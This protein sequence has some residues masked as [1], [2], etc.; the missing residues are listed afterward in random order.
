MKP[1]FPN[2]CWKFLIET[3][4]PVAQFFGTI[5]LLSQRLF[6]SFRYL[7]YWLNAIDEHSLHAP[8][9]FKFYTE[10]IKPDE[11]LPVFQ[12]IEPYR[13]EKLKDH[14]VV[15]VGDLG[16]PSLVENG[17]RR[18]V[19]SIARHSLSS[20]KSSRLLWRLAH[21]IQPAHIIELGTSLGINT[22]YLSSYH[23]ACK[24]VTFE[25]CNTSIEQAASLFAQWET[26]NIE[27]ISGNIDDTLPKYLEQ[28]TP[29]DM[30]YLDA[31]HRYEPTMKY[32][33]LLMNH[34]SPTSVL[35]LDDIHWSAEME[36]AWRKI[37]QHKKVTLSIDIFDAGLVFFKP[38]LTKQ[39]Y[40]LSF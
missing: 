32:F 15:H 36:H 40:T 30:V 31:N 28:Y 8:F 6:L 29:V 39:H 25:G 1:S 22:L 27:L 20:A 13:K 38:L 34:L 4:D 24:V 33:N 9:I 11:H 12:K 23:P 17:S 7:H 16:A 14:R 35:V 18:K 3:I 19:S 37:K 5:T 21:Y 26:K 10:V 2:L